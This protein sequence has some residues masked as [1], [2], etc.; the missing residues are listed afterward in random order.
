MI[1][2]KKAKLAQLLK[3]AKTLQSEIE[4]MEARAAIKEYNKQIGKIN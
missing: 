3:E 1:E 4:W 2:K